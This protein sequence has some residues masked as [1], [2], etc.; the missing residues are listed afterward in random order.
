FKD[1]ESAEQIKFY[2]RQF[3]S[4]LAPT[5]YI[6]TNPEV[7]RE[8]VETEGACLKQGLENF[9]QDWENSSLEAFRIT[10][11][12]PTAFSLGDN[13]AT[14]PGKVVFQNDLIQLIQYQPATRQVFKRPV[15]ITPPFINK[16]YILDLDEKKSLVRWLVSQGY[17]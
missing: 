15:L 11:T 9:I 2:T 12:D 14:T 5:N 7:H 16:Y 6:L 8:I 4:S 13:L 1:K 10:Q 3:V 17:T